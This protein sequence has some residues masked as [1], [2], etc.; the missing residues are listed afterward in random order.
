MC[1]PQ[2]PILSQM[3]AVQAF[4][5]MHFIIVLAI[6]T[7]TKLSLLFWLSKVW[8]AFFKFLK[9]S[10]HICTCIYNFTKETYSFIGLMDKWAGI[11]IDKKTNTVAFSPQTNYTD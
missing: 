8:F 11:H 5:Q 7:V 4:F 9:G 6:Y 1:A 10:E 3:K 2:G